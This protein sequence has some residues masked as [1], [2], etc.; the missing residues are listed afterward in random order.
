MFQGHLCSHCT[1]MPCHGHQAIDDPQSHRR[2]AT[3]RLLIPRRG[4]RHLCFQC[5]AS[6]SAPGDDEPACY[7]VGTKQQ[8]VQKCMGTKQQQAHCPMGTKIASPKMHGHRAI[9][10]L[11]SHGHQATASLLFTRYGAAGSKACASATPVMPTKQPQRR[12]IHQQWHT[13]WP[14]HPRL[15]P[16]RRSQKNSYLAS[17]APLT[18]SPPASPP[19]TCKK[20]SYLASA[21]PVSQDST[22]ATTI[23]HL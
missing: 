10:S 5:A 19:P 4:Q 9:A 14:V 18:D 3:V 21:A 2:L 7:M 22:P 20:Y 6:P 12:H 11:M 8:R 1:G 13:R 17:A 23:T 15:P 16:Y